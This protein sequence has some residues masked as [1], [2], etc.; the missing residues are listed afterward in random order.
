MAAP[1]PTKLDMPQVLNRVFDEANGLLRTSSQSTIV[2]A[3]I[4]VSLDATEDNVAIRDAAGHELDINPDGSINTVVSGNLEI[5]I[6]AAD[7]DNIAISDGIDT[8]AINADGS[9]NVVVGGSGGV[10]SS[11]YTEVLGVV[12]GITTL[13]G[14]YTAVINDFLQK[15][16]FSGTNIAEYELVIN[17]ITQDKKR[18]Y[19]GSS[20]NGSFDFNDGLPVP[21]GQVIEI[22]VVHNRPSTGDFNSRIQTREN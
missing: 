19:F 2:N 17:G 15:I 6:D 1:D 9:I 8:L 22:Y 7:G 13:I 3:D 4:D 16:D 21:A 12:A 11:K 14:T 10:I 18:T 5:E 20:L